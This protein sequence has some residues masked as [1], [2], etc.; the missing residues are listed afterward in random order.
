MIDPT[1]CSFCH[2]DKSEVPGKLL[3]SGE[4]AAICA[5][6]V[7]TSKQALLRDESSQQ[8]LKP[9]FFIRKVK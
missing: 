6:C 1:Y 7:R 3:V 8:V 2:R 9:P 5:D 4:F